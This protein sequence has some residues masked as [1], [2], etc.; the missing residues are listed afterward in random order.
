[1]REASVCENAWQ[2]APGLY[3]ILLP[4]PGD[5][6]FVSVFLVESEGRRLLVDAGPLWPTALRAL[7]RALKAIGV[8]PG[9]IDTILLTHRHP[10]HAGGSGPV[11]ERWGGRTL[12]HPRDLAHPW[13]DEAAARAWAVD[14]GVP[15]AD[16]ARV[17]RSRPAG[18][19]RLPG[20]VLPLEVR[21][22]L[23]VGRRTFEVH[24]APGHCPGQVLLREVGEGWLFAADQIVESLAPNVWLGPGLSGDPFGAYL[25]SLERV[26]GLEATLVLPS[27]GMP[28]EGGPAAV[29][30]RQLGFARDYLGR[31]LPLVEPGGS[32][33]WQVAE[34]L[35]PER[36]DAAALAEVLAALEHLARRG[37]LGRRGGLWLP[38]GRRGAEGGEGLG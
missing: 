31:V 2:L 35:Q 19:E 9:G 38:Q 12:L 13:A 33:A 14:C 30:D 27:H 37:D 11:Q 3:R 1:M 10:D 16:A 22:P 29:A 24:E 36:R 7:G 32:T 23:R 25:A 5:V 4:L 20:D 21:E 34:R 28:L 15:P 18:R 17:A 6:P 26:R 8:P